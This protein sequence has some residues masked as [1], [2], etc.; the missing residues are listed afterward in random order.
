[1]K[2]NGAKHKSGFD[3]EQIVSQ[4]DFDSLYEDRVRRK[5]VNFWIDEDYQFRY[6]EIQRRTRY[7]FGKEICRLI[8]MCVD[9]CEIADPKKSK[10]KVPA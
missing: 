1:M 3:L 10:D 9:R 6:L 8:E 2:D 5:Q 4:V 7:R